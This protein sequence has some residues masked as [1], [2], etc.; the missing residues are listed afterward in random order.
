MATVEEAKKRKYNESDP[1][2]EMSDDGPPTPHPDFQQGD[3]TIISSDNWSFKV[4][5]YYLQAH[6][7]AQG[8]HKVSMRL[9]STADPH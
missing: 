4:A 5:R 2:L 3:I 8:S 6:R 7:L 9:R 1:E